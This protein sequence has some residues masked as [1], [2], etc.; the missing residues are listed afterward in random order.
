M[1]VGMNEWLGVFECHMNSWSKRKSDR[2]CTPMHSSANDASGGLDTDEGTDRDLVEATI[3]VQEVEMSTVALTVLREQWQR[4]LDIDVDPLSIDEGKQLDGLLKSI[5]EWQAKAKDILNREQRV[6]ADVSSGAGPMDAVDRPMD[7]VDRPMDAVDRPM[8]AVDRPMDAVDDLSFLSVLDGLAPIPPPSKRKE[9]T[10][11]LRGGR[12]FCVS[13]DELDSLAAFCLELEWLADSRSLSFVPTEEQ[14]DERLTIDEVKQLVRRAQDV[15]ALA[16]VQGTQEFTVLQKIVHHA[17]QITQKAKALVDE[18]VSQVWPKKA[19]KKEK[20]G[21]AP[22]VDSAETKQ[23][24]QSL[25]AVLVNMRKFPALLPEQQLVEQQLCLI[26]TKRWLTVTKERLWSE[27]EAPEAA[28]KAMQLVELEEQGKKLRRTSHESDSKRAP[29]EQAIFGELKKQLQWVQWCL[30]VTAALEEE[31][32]TGEASQ[33]VEGGEDMDTLAAGGSTKKEEA[34]ENVT[35][36]LHE[37]QLMQRIDSS[38][39]ATAKQA[40][41]F[42]LFKLRK[43]DWL[44]RVQRVLRAGVRSAL[45]VVEALCADAS[46]LS[47]ECDEEKRV[48]EMVTGAGFLMSRTRT[49]LSTGGEQA[50]GAAGEGGANVEAN[51]EG[52]ERMEHDLKMLQQDMSHHLVLLPEQWLVEQQLLILEW[53]TLVEECMAQQ[54]QFAHLVVLLSQYHSQH[55]LWSHKAD[56]CT[57]K[58]EESAIVVRTRSRLQERIKKAKEWLQDPALC[59]VLSTKANGAVAVGS[60]QDGTADSVG[61]VAGG[62]SCGPPLLSDL[63][64]LLE[65]PV[66]KWVAMQEEERARTLVTE[67]DEWIDQAKDYLESPPEQTEDPHDAD[68][69]DELLKKHFA[70]LRALYGES[71]RLPVVLVESQAIDALTQLVKWVQQ[72]EVIGSDCANRTATLG[73]AS[74]LLKKTSYI[75][76]AVEEVPSSNAKRQLLTRA[77]GSKERLTQTVETSHGWHNSASQ[78]LLAAASVKE[79]ERLEQKYQTALVLEVEIR[80]LVQCEIKWQK[81][82]AHLRGSSASLIEE[83]G[84]DAEDIDEGSV[85]WGKMNGFPFWPCVFGGNRDPEPAKPAKKKSKKS[86]PEKSHDGTCIVRWVRP[87][88]PTENG[89]DLIEVDPM[90]ACVIRRSSLRQWF[91]GKYPSGPIPKHKLHEQAVRVAQLRYEKRKEEERQGNKQ[92]GVYPLVGIEE[93]EANMEYDA[94]DLATASEGSEDED[95]ASLF[96]KRKSRLRGEKKVCLGP[97]CTNP[98]Q[99]GKY[100]K[101]LCRLRGNANDKLGGLL[102]WRIETRESIDNGDQ[103]DDASLSHPDVKTEKPIRDK[104]V[105]VLTGALQGKGRSDV[106]GA[107]VRAEALA[108]LIEAEMYRENSFGEGKKEAYK[109]KYRSLQFNLKDPKNPGLLMRVVAGDLTARALCALTPQDMANPEMRKWR[110]KVKD[111]KMTE[112]VLLRYYISYTHATFRDQLPFITLRTRFAILHVCADSSLTN[113]PQSQQ[114]KPSYNLLSMVFGFADGSATVTPRQA[115][116]RVAKAKACVVESPEPEKK[117]EQQKEKRRVVPLV[118]KEPPQ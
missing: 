39:K 22:D 110:Q 86:K 28:Q 69:Q 117:A 63:K 88:W 62:S 108:I 8:D 84:D 116:A 112:E 56:R 33:D 101:G 97:S 59:Y 44:C 60:A 15:E 50:E 96:K 109:A 9:F 98:V 49:I 6:Y 11:L 99:R 40:A 46:A 57:E 71:L 115:G 90:S 4:L 82:N 104:V 74:F 61:R 26:Q 73:Y 95:E 100:C 45:V 25:S 30:K 72:V 94:S 53:A 27:T 103:E 51:V 89:Q 76:N 14:E 77:R 42:I 113:Q 37:V 107:G 19:G 36:L 38:I 78:A 93:D 7:A 92:M 64:Q 20:E 75:L 118:K 111:K 29:R 18:S 114:T 68:A 66:L 105:A 83:M 35:R 54:A 48:R 13:F 31:A 21:E 17:Q 5:S 23:T 55:A 79:L 1:P 43:L 85:C 16:N 106:D 32:T 102:R 91:G 87:I 34:A 67:A 58:Y 65:H 70:V 81:S 52:Y 41:G 12:S 10:E 24:E 47:I 80:D 2:K 3:S